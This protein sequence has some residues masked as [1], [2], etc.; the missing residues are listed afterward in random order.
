MNDKRNFDYKRLHPF[1]W[2][3]LENYPFLEDSIDALTNYELFCKLGKMY[4]KQVDAI[5]TLGV[6][7]EGITDWFDNLDVQDEINNKLDA[8][9]E[10]GTMD[11]IINQE[12]FGQI[13]QDIS[14]VDTKIGDLD[15]LIT[16]NRESIVD[17]INTNDQLQQIFLGNGIKYDINEDLGHV[18]G[19][20]IY[21][22]NLYVA[23]QGSNNY[24]TIFVFNI[25]SN[26]YVT[27]YENI[28]MYHGNDLTII[29]NKIYIASYDSLK[30]CIYD[31]TT[32]ITTEI[33][34][35]SS[36]EGEY[37]H[38]LSVEKVDDNNILCWLE[39]S[40]GTYTLLNDKFLKLDLNSLTYTEYTINDPYNLTSFNGNTITRQNVCLDNNNLYILMA[41]PSIIFHANIIDNTIIFNKIYNLPSKD[42][43]GNPV[44]ELE[45]L[46]IINNINYPDGSIM[47]T[48]RT[49]ETF[50]NTNNIFGE[51]TIN[52]Y[53]FSP[54]TGN[55]NFVTLA[56]G[57]YPV[58]GT[59]NF[60]YYSVSKSVGNLVEDGTAGRPFKNL[61]RGI[62]CIMN[63][64]YNPAILQIIDSSEYYIPFL[65][66]IKNLEIQV[67]NNCNPTIY[68]G[69][70][71]NC[72]IKFITTGNGTLTIK[73]LSN[74]N[75]R[76]NS[77]LSD[78][79]FFGNNGNSIIF[80]NL[81]F[82]A[83]QCSFIRTRRCKYEN[84]EDINS[85][86]AFTLYDSSTII[87]GF[88]T[89]TLYG[90]QKWLS[91]ASY[92]TAFSS[93][94]DITKNGATAIINLT[95]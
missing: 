87:D 14:D 78:L 15:N 81:Q 84:T 89:R 94:N 6:Q 23:V 31:M 66:G 55:V 22:N 56:S 75:K 95:T 58:R 28:L 10:D 79:S 19:S 16:P 25:V 49:F 13:N 3:I 11:E 69:D 12:I 85:S 77:F 82:N 17:A 41:L 61:M 51:D 88:D 38:I 20:C 86:Y 57:Q 44:G 5:N 93:S 80:N 90:S 71:E 8:M 42:I 91:L 73:G 64:Q 65:Y 59:N 45:S 68:L 76:I 2:Y 26:T 72:N 47:I 46:A 53:I 40:S 30:I 7:V 70:F 4:N 60:G 37:G 48:G 52:T 24:G 1:K 29:D 43:T 39:K 83:N 50:K 36:L 63:A 62:N 33:N 34:P 18:Q 27:K 74:N 21:N 92:S 35:F 9:V 32:N 67:N 54:K